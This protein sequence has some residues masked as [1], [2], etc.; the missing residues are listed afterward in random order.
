MDSL[1]DENQDLIDLK[2]MQKSINTQNF[3]RPQNL[4]LLDEEIFSLF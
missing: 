2:C 4:M 3:K 1:K